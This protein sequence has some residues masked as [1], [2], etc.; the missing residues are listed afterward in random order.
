MTNLKGLTLANVCPL[1]LVY[2]CYYTNRCDPVQRT[3]SIDVIAD[4]DHR[5]NTPMIRNILCFEI[6][7]HKKIEKFV[8][9]D[10]IFCGLAILLPVLRFAKL[11][12]SAPLAVRWASVVFG[13]VLRINLYS[14]HSC[15][16]FAHDRGVECM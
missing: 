6:H 4:S 7:F 16:M 3:F 9:P 11:L 14:S 15:P 5:D 13:L 1:K 10:C 2:R 12:P 8:F